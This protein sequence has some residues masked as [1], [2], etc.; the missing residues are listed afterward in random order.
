MREWIRFRGWAAKLLAL[1]HW[2]VDA[3]GLVGFWRVARWMHPRAAS[4][5]A[6]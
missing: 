1:P 5:S 2:A 6:V 4:C 3:A